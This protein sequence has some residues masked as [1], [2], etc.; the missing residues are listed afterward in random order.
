MNQDKLNKNIETDMYSV[1]KYHVQ[2][3]SI[4]TCIF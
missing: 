4:F 3:L 1:C 2:E